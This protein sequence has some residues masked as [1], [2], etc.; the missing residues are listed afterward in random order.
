M[1]FKEDGCYE[2]SVVTIGNNHASFDSG[3]IQL[4]NYE[5]GVLKLPSKIWRSFFH[6]FRSYSVRTPRA[7]KISFIVPQMHFFFS[8]FLIAVLPFK[9]GRK[10]RP[11]R[12]RLPRPPS[13]PDPGDDAQVRLSVRVWQPGKGHQDQRVL[14]R[15]PP[16]VGPLHGAAHPVVLLP[17]GEH[18]DGPHVS[19][20][21]R[22]PVQEGQPL[23]ARTETAH[24]LG[25]GGRGLGHGVD[26]DGFQYSLL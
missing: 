13:A 8:L 7:V 18:E 4:F 3:K 9:L 11:G 25:E 12:G 24:V 10:R 21:G 16:E 15:A 5:S 17:G 19:V 1:C 23:P 6:P 14:L 20:L 26:E 2:S 22:Q